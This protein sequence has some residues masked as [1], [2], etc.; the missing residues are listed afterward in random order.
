MTKDWHVCLSDV[1]RPRLKTV[2]AHFSPVEFLAQVYGVQKPNYNNLH[3]VRQLMWDCCLDAESLM[4][5][6]LEPWSYAEQQ[7]KQL[8]L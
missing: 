1:I 5:H 6:R 4:E 7:Q 2:F 8:R 3:V